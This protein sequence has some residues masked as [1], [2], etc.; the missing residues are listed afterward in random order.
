M[1]DPDDL[2]KVIASG[3]DAFYAWI[4]Y[5]YMS[6]AFAVSLNRLWS[7]LGDLDRERHALMVRMALKDKQDA[8]EAGHA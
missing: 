5:D 4:R 8:M 2:A 1:M 3:F 6:D 7:D